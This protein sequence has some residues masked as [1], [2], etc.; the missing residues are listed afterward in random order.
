M[1]PEKSSV[2]S[3]SHATPWQMGRDASLQQSQLSVVLPK[4]RQSLVAYG[5]KL[6]KGQGEASVSR[7]ALGWRGSLSFPLSS[8]A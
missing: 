8:G 6:F 1:G 3:P 2:L 4:G 7:Q 5:S